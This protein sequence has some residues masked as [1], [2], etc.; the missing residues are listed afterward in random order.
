MVVLGELS[1][2]ARSVNR[3]LRFYRVVTRT[4]SGGRQYCPRRSIWTRAVLCKCTNVETAG[5]RLCALILS[6]PV[7]HYHRWQRN[8]HK[9]INNRYLLS[10]LTLSCRRYHRPW[11]EIARDCYTVDVIII[12]GLSPPPRSVE[13]AHDTVPERSDS[14]TTVDVSS[15]PIRSFGTVLFRLR[16]N[17]LQ[18]ISCHGEI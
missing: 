1:L 8:A 9:H 15:R 10:Y 2:Y 5:G 11:R 16:E 14:S 18:S 12:E 6:S 4:T 13:T 7:Q 17:A 3:R